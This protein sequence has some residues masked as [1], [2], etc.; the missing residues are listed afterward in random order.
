[1][2]SCERAPTARGCSFDTANRGARGAGPRLGLT[3]FSPVR[4]CR[5]GAWK[6]SAHPIDA[7]AIAAIPRWRSIA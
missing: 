1:M 6:A 3:P 7:T 5:R 2:D 4:A